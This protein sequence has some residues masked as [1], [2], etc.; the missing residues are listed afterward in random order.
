MNDQ[1][2][3]RLERASARF[4]VV[5]GIVHGLGETVCE[6]FYDQSLA[7][8][9]VDYI[10]VALLLYTGLSFL[11]RASTAAAGLLAGAWG[12]TACLLYR[13]FF[14]RFDEFLAKGSTS[15]AEPDWFLAL[16][17]LEFTVIALSF[18]GSMY[19][20]FQRGKAA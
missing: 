1:L 9:L 10:A 6:W 16:L 18:A 11:L 17:G 7:M 12:F 20:V 5:V 2:P 14:E 15:L 13:V 8:L 4:A 19:L 3:T